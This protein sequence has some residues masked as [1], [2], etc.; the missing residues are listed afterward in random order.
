MVLSQS[1]NT[2]ESD[3]MGQELLVELDK[4]PCDIGKCLALIESG[5]NTGAKNAKG[6]TALFCSY[7]TVITALIKKGADT[8][9]RNSTRE[10]ALMNAAFW[11]ITPCV[12]ALLDGGANPLEK[13]SAG[14]TAL[15][16]AKSHQKY[17][18]NATVEL[19]EGAERRWKTAQPQPALK[20]A[21]PELHC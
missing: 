20:P 9:T 1:F 2:A 16:L 7:P 19:L 11:G 13:N 15:A 6:E 5:A 21:V 10:T 12:K 14:Q 4:Y 18:D 3:R 17:G 8:D